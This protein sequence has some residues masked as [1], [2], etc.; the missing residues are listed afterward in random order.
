MMNAAANRPDL[1]LAP[2]DICVGKKVEYVSYNT[3][4]ARGVVTV[5]GNDLGR[6]QNWGKLLIGAGKALVRLTYLAKPGERPQFGFDH[7]SDPE[8]SWSK[9]S[10]AQALVISLA[11]LRMGLMMDLFWHFVPHRSELWLIWITMSIAN[12][13]EDS[14][15]STSLRSLVPSDNND[16]NG[17]KDSIGTNSDNDN[18]QQNYIP[19]HKVEGADG[20]DSEE[21]EELIQDLAE[22]YDD[23]DKDDDAEDFSE[24]SWVKGDI[25][26]DYHML[27]LP[28]KSPVRK[29]IL[30]LVIHATSKFVADDLKNVVE[31]V[32]RNLG[33]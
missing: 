17:S 3:V 16:H 33:Y 28:K 10:T 22:D 12:G 11:I 19:V 4:I 7:L 9:E 24:Q 25:W 14:F 31:H 6:S 26:H 27:P 30:S 13:S 8:K 2:H 1:Y 15:R 20:I 23:F 32:E 29:L 18:E 5:V 21:L